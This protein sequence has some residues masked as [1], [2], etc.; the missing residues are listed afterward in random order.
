[1]ALTMDSRLRGNDVIGL[2][3]T[4]DADERVFDFPLWTL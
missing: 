3:P 2:L 1:M 4:P